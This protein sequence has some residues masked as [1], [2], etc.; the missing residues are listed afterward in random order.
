MKSKFP[1]TR[2]VAIRK[3]SETIYMRNMQ[4]LIFFTEWYIFRES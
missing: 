3:T 4:H 2:Q 1:E